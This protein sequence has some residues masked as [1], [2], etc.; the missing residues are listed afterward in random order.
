MTERLASAN[1]IELAY[2]TFGD[3]ADPP[4]VL[5]MGLGMQLIH[6][7]PEL[8]G[9]LAEEGF[10][11]IRFDN[12]DVGRSSKIEGGPRPTLWAQL[13]GRRS[14]ASYMLG[15][16]LHRLLASSFYKCRWRFLD[17]CEQ[18]YLRNFTPCGDS[19]DML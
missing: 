7:D 9:L 12:R 4:L 6:W 11:V 16:L 8:C 10:R 18:S 1:G 13:T 14:S 3:P 5:V 15:N 2:E 17:Y 19:F